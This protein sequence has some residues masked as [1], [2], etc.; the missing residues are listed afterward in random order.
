MDQRLHLFGQVRDVLVLEQDLVA[1]RAPQ[2]RLAGL[3]RLDLGALRRATRGVISAIDLGK[4]RGLFVGGRLR[5]KVLRAVVR[6]GDLTGCIGVDALGGICA[7]AQAV[8]ERCFEQDID[9]AI[10]RRAR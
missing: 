9:G 1:D 2:V 7:T 8:D 10:G 6:A 4:E 5:L 3:V